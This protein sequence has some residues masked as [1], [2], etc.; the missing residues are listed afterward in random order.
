MD[1]AFG[2]ISKNYLP[3]PRSQKFSLT[4]SSGNFIVLGFTFRY[5][6][7]LELIFICGVQ[8]SVSVFLPP[9]IEKTVLSPLDCLFY[10]YQKLVTHVFV[11]LFLNSVFY[12]HY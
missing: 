7:H 5:M 2:I 4:F 3:S 11:G 8:V 12:L 9:L 1:C 10:L 6:F